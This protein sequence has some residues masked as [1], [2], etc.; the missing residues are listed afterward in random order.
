MKCLKKEKIRAFIDYELTLS[1][2]KNVK[3]HISECSYCQRTLQEVREEI[4][5]TQRTL[6]LLSPETVPESP[7]HLLSEMEEKKYQLTFRKFILSPIRVPAVVLV[8]IISFL[9][10]MSFMLLAKNQRE[11][12]SRYLRSPEEKKGTLSFIMEDFVQSISLSVDSE[13]IKPIEN[14]RVI[15]LKEFVK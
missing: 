13:E 11:V 15:V 5:L 7:S 3:R 6:E 9:L 4:K 10:V 8:F 12:S 1:E 14:P 2:V